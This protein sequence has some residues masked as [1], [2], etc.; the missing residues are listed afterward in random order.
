MSRDRLS[1]ILAVFLAALAA[2]AAN[3]AT[4]AGHRQAQITPYPVV[5]TM[6]GPATAFS[7][8]EITY[9]VRYRLTDPA[10]IPSTDIVVDIPRGARYVSSRV[11]SGPPG[12]LVVAPGERHARWAGLGS[13]KETEGAVQVSVRI[14]EGFL[15]TT[16][17]SC[18]VPGTQTSNPES[19]CH[20]ETQ[21]F[22]QATLPETGSD[23][24]SAAPVRSLVLVLA[25]GGVAL[26]CLGFSRRYVGSS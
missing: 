12:V 3:I 23:G 16:S 13:A 26:A 25:V 4:A 19:R 14:D 9:T 5:L 6:T 8:E 7:G 20:V 22:A 18:Y 11:I 24:R 1:M 21:V 2:T 15:G 10:T 17:S